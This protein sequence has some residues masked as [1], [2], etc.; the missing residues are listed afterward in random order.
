MFHQPKLPLLEEAIAA[1]A[2][3]E[4]RLKLTKTGEM[5]ASRSAFTMSELKEIRDCFNGELEAEVTPGG[6]IIPVASRQ[7]WLTLG[8]LPTLS[9]QEK[10]ILQMHLYP[11]MI[12]FQIGY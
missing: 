3:E 2:Q 6:R 11:H 12:S 5:N 10:V 1:M 7:T 9:T 4:V 8:T